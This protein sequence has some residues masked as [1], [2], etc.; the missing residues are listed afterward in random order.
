[1][2]IDEPD[3]HLH[4]SLQLK[5][6]DYLRL[7][8]ADGRTQFIIATHSPTIA[9]YATFDELFLLRPIELVQM[10][11]NQLIQVASDEQRLSLLRDIF[12]T[13]SNLT[14]M[15]PIVVVEGPDVGTPG[16]AVPDRKLYRA[17]HSR[18]DRVILVSGGGK[19][20][21]IKLVQSLNGLI[22][23]FSRH[24][25]AVALLDQDLPQTDP[26]PFVRYLPVSMIENFLLDP[27]AIWEAIQSVLERTSFSSVEDVQDALNAVIDS[28]ES[29]ELSRRALRSFGADVF[30]PK[31]P[32]ES[33]S[34]QVA[35]FVA[36]LNTKYSLERI[37]EAIQAANQMIESI[38]AAQKRRELFDGKA[39]LEEFYKLYISK[40]GMSRGIFTYESARH[41]RRRKSVIKFFEEF[42][43]Q[44]ISNQARTT[45]VSG[46]R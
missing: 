32:I 41:A 43:Q 3:L 40:T 28:F 8:S 31:P 15:Q 5:V 2:L 9:E 19:T 34:G 46:Q 1:V 35:S 27:D 18:F 30:R 45:S 25:R 6:F 11:E 36:S 16:K 24:I 39:L 14:A 26:P 13:T 7:L 42:H 23:E 17:L 4:P 21:C 38:K 20:E 33:T 12:G 10:G 29:Q 37:D 44:L 22:Q